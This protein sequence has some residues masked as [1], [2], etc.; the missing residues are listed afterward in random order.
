[1]TKGRAALGMPPISP[2][3]YT[4]GR[5][6]TGSMTPPAES[7]ATTPS[8]D[9]MPMVMLFGGSPTKGASRSGLVILNMRTAPVLS[10]RTSVV[11]K[12]ARFLYDPAGT[13][14]T[15]S[16]QIIALSK[17]PF[18]RHG[19]VSPAQEPLVREKD[20]GMVA[21]LAGIVPFSSPSMVTLDP[22]AISPRTW[23]V[24][25]I[26]LSALGHGASCEML[27]VT[28]V[29]GSTLSGSELSPFWTT[30]SF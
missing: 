19:L 30:D 17:M 7:V 25:M 27:L 26:V 10:L 13:A 1:M 15:A 9:E 14:S 28:R 2:W 3:S 8:L 5:S 4:R 24:T 6:A 23:S 11:V 16:C 12:T 22:E 21:P 29:I 18:A 20:L